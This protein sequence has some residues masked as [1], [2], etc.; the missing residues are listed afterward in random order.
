[1]GDTL[2]DTADPTNCLYI[3]NPINDPYWLSMN[4]VMTTTS[5]PGF[6]QTGVPNTT[7]VTVT[8]LG[9]EGC[10]FPPDGI[11][12]IDL[13]ISNEDP[14]LPMF[15]ATV[16]GT[17]DTIVSSQLIATTMGGTPIAT[18]VSWNPST[19]IGTG[20]RCLLARVYPPE[21]LSGSFPANEDLTLFPS[22]DTHYAQHNCTVGA[23]DTGD[24]IVPIK[25]GNWREEPYFVAIQAVP[26]LKP[27][28]TVLDAVLPGLRLIPAFKQIATTPLQRVELDVTAFRSHHDSLLEKIEDW[29]EEEVMKIIK[30]LEGKCRQ[31][32]GASARVVLPP[33]LVAK[34][35]LNLDLSGAKPGDA[36]I[37]HVSQVDGKGQPYGGLTVA[38]VRT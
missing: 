26:D 31:A 17:L 32:G 1:M 10:S 27:N 19:A 33:N 16:G 4:L 30:E 15:H 11:V 13:F 23:V 24:M 34:F 20:H 37:Y 9:N 25:N 14:S 7:N 21:D 36:H 3:Q 5:D 38:V 18:Q 8:W 6:V 35:N 28:R 2:I 22:N 12:V 29:I